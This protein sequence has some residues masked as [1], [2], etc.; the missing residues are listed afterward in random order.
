MNIFFIADTHFGHRNICKYRPFNSVEE[1]DETIIEKWNAVVHKK[2]SI[3][4]V[5]GD[6][7]FRDDNRDI[8]SIIYKLNGK[9]KI[10]TGNHDYMPYINELAKSRFIE[11]ERGIMK[12]YGYWLSHCPMHPQELRG[13]KNIHG[14]VHSKSVPDERYINVSCDTINYTPI[15]LEQIRE[16]K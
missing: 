14:H 15:S 1:H 3:V 13:H 16:L 10:V 12:K 8:L 6:F 11:L 5:L 4:Y 9:I 7:M 2:R